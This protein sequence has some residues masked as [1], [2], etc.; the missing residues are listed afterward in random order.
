MNLKQQREAAL[1]AARD[2]AEK[3]QGLRRREMTRTTRSLRSN[4]QLAKADDL[5]RQIKAADESQARMKRLAEIE[6]PRGRRGG[7][8]PTR[9]RSVSTSSRASATSWLE[10]KAHRAAGSRCP[11]RSSRPPPTP[12]LVGSVFDAVTTQVDTNIVPGLRRRL[13]IADLLGQGTLSGN[14]ITYYVEGALEGDFTTV[15]EGAAKAADP[16]RRPD[17]GHRGAEEDRGVHQGV[18]RDGR[19]SAVPGR[20]RSTT[21][22]CTTSACSRRTRSST[23]TAR[24]PT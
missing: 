10:A 6:D 23:A 19:G 9:S 24:A 12:R 21:G 14:A 17:P 22:C 18:R 8:R 20:P 1:K 5:R 11:R 15:A 7:R 4:Q 16:L 13:T 2:I 3:R